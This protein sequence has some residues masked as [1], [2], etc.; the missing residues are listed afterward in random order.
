M[1]NRFSFTG[2][3][4]LTLALVAV[5]A[6]PGISQTPESTPSAGAPQSPSQSAPPPSATPPP[7]TQPG[8]APGTS[9]SPGQAPGNAQAQSGEDENP[10]GL[11]E[12]QKNQL[13]PIVTEETQQ[14]EAVRNDNSL[15]ADQK[16][17]KINQIREA[18]SPKIKAILTP[19]QLQKLAEMQRARQ[20]QQQPPAPQR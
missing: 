6:T 20:Q 13:R 7:T 3:V 18:A 15:S 12:D 9:S 2:I 19:A 14:L 16:I 4:L 1:R 8:N 11:T 17:A 10:L 5:A